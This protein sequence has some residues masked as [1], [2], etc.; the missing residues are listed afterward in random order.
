MVD[1]PPALHFGAHRRGHAL[2]W[3]GARRRGTGLGHR[4]WHLALDR[5]RTWRLA[6]CGGAGNFAWRLA[7]DVRTGHGRPLAGLG[8]Q[9]RRIGHG[10]G[11]A[12]GAFPHGWLAGIGAADRRHAR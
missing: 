3:R 10:P 9:A 5:L 12:C 4:P 1:L 8:A 11:D 7:H 6:H 2:G